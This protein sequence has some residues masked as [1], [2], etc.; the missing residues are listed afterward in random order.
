MI[1]TTLFLKNQTQPMHQAKDD[2]YSRTP[3]HKSIMN[4]YQD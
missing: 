3:I 2:T 1:S 4:F